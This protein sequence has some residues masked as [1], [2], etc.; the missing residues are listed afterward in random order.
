MVFRMHFPYST[1]KWTLIGHV[2]SQ[3][4]TKDSRSNPTPEGL[5]PCPRILEATLQPA[6]PYGQTKEWITRI[7][8]RDL[9]VQPF[10]QNMSL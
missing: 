3:P 10:K 1:P 9:Y 8:G 2:G 6:V 4:P 5:N 7:N